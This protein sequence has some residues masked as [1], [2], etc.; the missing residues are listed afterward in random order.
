[1]A[2]S[3]NKSRY[4]GTIRQDIVSTCRIQAKGII[5]KHNKKNK[6]HSKWEIKARV[7]EYP[8]IIMGLSKDIQINMEL[9]KNVN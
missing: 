6:R 2:G 1:L 8:G 7:S 3:T 4:Y 5:S 9:H